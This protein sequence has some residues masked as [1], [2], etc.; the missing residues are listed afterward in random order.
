[1]FIKIVWVTKDKLGYSSRKE[2]IVT[3]DGKECYDILNKKIGENS[4]QNPKL[5]NDGI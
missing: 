1:M 2:N 5:S 4:I 3:N